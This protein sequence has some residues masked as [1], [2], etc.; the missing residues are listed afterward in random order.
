[1]YYSSISKYYNFISSEPTGKKLS[2]ILTYCSK[3]FT[4]TLLLGCCFLGLSPTQSH[5]TI[6]NMDEVGMT[7]NQ[8][9]CLC[10]LSQIP[11]NWNHAVQLVFM[12]GIS[13][14]KWWKW[15]EESGFFHSSITLTLI[16]RHTAEVRLASSV[17]WLRSQIPIPF[18]PY[19]NVCLEINK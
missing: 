15:Q 2:M 6:S 18:L 10:D 4:T 14:V 12:V 7:E 16:S 8:R 13:C 3:I 19:L 9:Y 1:M 11:E 5:L 17:L